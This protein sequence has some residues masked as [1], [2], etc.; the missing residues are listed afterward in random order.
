MFDAQGVRSL[1]EYVRRAAGG[2]RA[3]DDLGFCCGFVG[4]QRR[5]AMKNRNTDLINWNNALSDGVGRS[6]TRYRLLYDRLAAGNAGG[7]WLIDVDDVT[8][9]SVKSAQGAFARSEGLEALRCILQGQS[10]EISDEHY[11]AA[12]IIANEMLETASEALSQSTHVDERDHL[13]RNVNALQ[14]LSNAIRL[15][16]GRRQRESE[17]D[18]LPP[19]HDALSRLH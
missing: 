10:Q 17:I 13:S 8:I 6:G 3:A 18:A 16:C 5:Q 1:A 14:A 9:C 12:G 11:R 7:L 19:L 4:I 2:H 15:E